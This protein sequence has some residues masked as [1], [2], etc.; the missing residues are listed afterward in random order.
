MTTKS[1]FLL[2]LSIP[3]YNPAKFLFIWLNR[4][5]DQFVGI[6]KEDIELIISHI[7][8][9]MVIFAVFLSSSR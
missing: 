8:V 5:K 4:I 6:A 2:S 9:W 1:N 3:T 7:W